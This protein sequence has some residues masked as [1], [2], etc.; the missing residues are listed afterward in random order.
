MHEIIC[1]NSLSNEVMSISLLA[2]EVLYENGF[3]VEYK[4]NGGIRI[5]K[6]EQSFDN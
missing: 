5:I 3:S 1:S 2:C 4:S 6:N